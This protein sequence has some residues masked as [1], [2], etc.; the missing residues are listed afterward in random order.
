MNPQ[1]DE[2]EFHI[3]TFCIVLAKNEARFNALESG[4]QENRQVILFSITTE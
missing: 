2:D 1:K 4:Q 3:L